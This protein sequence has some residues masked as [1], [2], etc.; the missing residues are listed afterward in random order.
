[1]IL[2]PIDVQNKEFK[3]ELFGFKKAEVLEF[4]KEITES[5]EKL[6]DELHSYHTEIENLKRQIKELETIKERTIQEAEVEAKRIKEEAKTIAIELIEQTKKEIARKEH[7]FELAM[8]RKKDEL[9]ALD[10]LKIKFLRRLRE[11]L[12]SGKKIVEFFESEHET[13]E[14]ARLAETLK[15]KVPAGEELLEE[16]VARNSKFK[17]KRKGLR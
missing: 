11:L 3:R 4:L 13:R 7:E 5:L 6:Y 9:Y 2:R 12:E 15:E 16:F 8:A 1:M 17:M 14:I 10:N